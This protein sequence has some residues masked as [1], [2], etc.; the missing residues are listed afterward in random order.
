MSV[1]PPSSLGARERSETAANAG[2]IVAVAVGAALRLSGL[3]ELPAG[4][5]GDEAVAGLEAQRILAEGY[6]GPYSLGALGQPTGPLYL[7]ALP[8]LLL[9]NTITA[10]R[11]V[12]AVIGISTIAAVYLFGREYGRCTGALAA[13]VLAV[14]GW[15]IHY[16]RIGVPLATW[17][18][19]AVIAAWCLSRAVSRDDLRWWIATGAVAAAGVY[20]YNGH[21]LLLGAFLLFVAGYLIVGRAHAL[22]RRVLGA[23]AV[24]V[25][26]LVCAVPMIRYALNEPGNYAFHFERY[27]I[28]NT[29]EW[30]QASSPAYRLSFL[31]GRYV[32]WWKNALWPWQVNGVDGIGYA[33]LVHPLTL[34]PLAAL[35]LVV[36]LGRRR[37]PAVVVAALIVGIMPV[38]AA[39]TVDD[40]GRRTSAMIPFLAFFAAIGVE[41]IARAIA[42]AWP[43]VRLAPLAVTAVAVGALFVTSALPYFLEFGASES[44]RWVFAADFTRASRFLADLPAESYVYMYSA[45]HSIEYET[46]RY[47]APDVRGED[48][49]TEYGHQTG[50]ELSSNDSSRQVFVLI[51]EYQSLAPALQERYP[52]AEVTVGEPGEPESPSF[53]AVSVPAPSAGATGATV[54]HDR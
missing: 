23:A 11:L 25:V 43:Q 17:G 35:G 15:H 42:R 40:V 3:E 22:E 16:A 9:G 29:E 50:I 4:L 52:A 32:D 30:Q 54:R 44:Q 47:L 20:V 36:A 31:A 46:R 37:H 21:P 34:A 12:P 26:L 49:S 39:L 7:F 51:G 45:R 8:I 10:V 41:S 53:V 5:H 6:V 33:P 28:V 1:G 27:S 14:N 13:L 2:L 19:I 24:V 48:R 38:S 18:L